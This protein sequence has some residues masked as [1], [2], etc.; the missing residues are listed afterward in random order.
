MKGEENMNWH[1]QIE[2]TLGFAEAA[3]AYEAELEYQAN[4]VIGYKTEA[5]YWEEY[6]A[7]KIC[8]YS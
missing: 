3:A 5:E 7:I 2:E 4:L 1:I 8:K 6:D